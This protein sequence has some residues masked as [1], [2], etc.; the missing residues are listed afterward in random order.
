[1][2]KIKFL[3]NIYLQPLLNLEELSYLTAFSLS[4]HFENKSSSLLGLYD[5]SV[6]PDNLLNKVFNFNEKIDSQ[7]IIS[8]QDV[9]I[10][11]GSLFPFLKSP[12]NFTE[13]SLKFS[14]IDFKNKKNFLDFIQYISYS[15]LFY[16]QHFFQKN[17]YAKSLDKKY[18]D[19]FY[20]HDF[21]GNLYFKLSDFGEIYRLTVNKEKISLFQGTYPVEIG[22][23]NYL[24]SS[25]F[26]YDIKIKRQLDYIYNNL[27]II[28]IKNN[29]LFEKEEIVFS[30]TIS[31]EL[32]K[33][34]QFNYLSNKL[35]SKNNIKDKLCKI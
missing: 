26:E 3:G 20:E 34:L 6:S 30:Y 32:E 23:K 21:L 35:H 7:R 24:I 29:S 22:K 13:K 14:L 17:C 27:S 12:I 11:T 9:S 16:Q 5:I 15:I 33:I 28:D 10:K 4:S 31:E 2:L 8:S 19:F 18:F 25:A 1:M